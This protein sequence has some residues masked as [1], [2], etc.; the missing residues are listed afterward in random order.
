MLKNVVRK[1][2]YKKLPQSELATFA[3]NV[4]Q[5]MIARPEYQAF[6]ADI[7]NLS[8]QTATYT[9]A[10]VDASGR[11][12]EAI[13][14][15]ELAKNNVIGALDRIAFLLDF[16]FTGQDVWVINAG[17]EMIR[18]GRQN[19]NKLEAPY[20]L[21]A[22]SK[23]V[24]GEITLQFRLPEPTRVRNNGVEY[25]VDHGETWHNGTYTSRT[26]VTVRGLPSRQVVQF[27]VCSLGSF[28]LKSPFSEGVEAFV[29]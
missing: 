12:T 4:Y 9:Q 7:T 25:S 28:Q 20:Q 15:K 5:R 11:G 22:T 18:A 27:R 19:Q 13:A 29:L 14:R 2:S 10:L 3:A 6:A 24:K 23:G 21:R 26:T 1:V 16:N 8:E 17:M